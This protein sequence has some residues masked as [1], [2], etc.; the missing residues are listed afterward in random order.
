LTKSQGN[1]LESHHGKFI[2]VNFAFGQGWKIG[3]KNW[4][5]SFYRAMLAQSAVMRQ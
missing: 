5:F 3:L 4:I 2:T 1:I